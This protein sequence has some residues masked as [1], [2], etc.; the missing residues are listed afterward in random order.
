MKYQ[1]RS[2]RRAFLK[3]RHMAKERREKKIQRKIRFLK[4][5][6]AVEEEKIEEQVKGTSPF[7]ILEPWKK[8]VVPT[9]NHVSFYDLKGQ[10]GKRKKKRRRS[11]KNINLR[12]HQLT[13]SGC[14]S[15]PV[16]LFIYFLYSKCIPAS[17]L[18]AGIS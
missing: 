12:H 18:V 10:K 9:K 14:P 11:R 7:G 15:K 16:C 6:K 5:Q 13:L 8:E 17:L 2:L 4:Q 3:N 1:S